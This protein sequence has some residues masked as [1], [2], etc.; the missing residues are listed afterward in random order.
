VEHYRGRERERNRRRRADPDRG[1]R[2][3]LYHSKRWLVLRRHILFEKPICAQPD[4]RAL[5][6]DVDHVVPLSQGGAE[7]EPDNLQPL[8]AYHHAIK[9][10]HEAGGPLGDAA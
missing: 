3:A 9:S 2:V 1:K 8:C 4:C 10:G 5:A 7:F 6:T